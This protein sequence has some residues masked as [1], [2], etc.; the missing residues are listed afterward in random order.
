M[1]Y[2]EQAESMEGQ[3]QDHQ[4][5]GFRPPLLC[6]SFFFFFPVFIHPS[7]VVSRMVGKPNGGS[8]EQKYRGSS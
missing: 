4:P 6:W 1:V 5:P 2:A 8:Y 3:S 7:A